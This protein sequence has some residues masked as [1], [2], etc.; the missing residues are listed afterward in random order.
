VGAEHGSNT[1][2]KIA[3]TFGGRTFNRHCNYLLYHGI[4]VLCKLTTIFRKTN[5]RKYHIHSRSVWL[6]NK[7]K[8]M[9]YGSLSDDKI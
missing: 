9:I 2:A 6:G 7:N 1:K 3:I 5:T 8:R 4:Q